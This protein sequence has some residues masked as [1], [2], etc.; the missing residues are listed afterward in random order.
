MH[1]PVAVWMTLASPRYHSANQFNEPVAATSAMTGPVLIT[2]SRIGDFSD[3][4]ILVPAQSMH[5]GLMQGF[6]ECVAT[7]WN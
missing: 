2:I 7:H 3:E 6:Q 4:F 5:S 1:C